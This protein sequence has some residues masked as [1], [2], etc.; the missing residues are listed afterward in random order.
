MSH[1]SQVLESFINNNKGMFLGNSPNIKTQAEVLVAYNK[2]IMQRQGDFKPSL[3]YY[4]NLIKN[5][6]VDLD[7]DN[8]W[9]AYEY[10]LPYMSAPDKNLLL[11]DL[12]IANMLFCAQ[13]LY[14]AAHQKTEDRENYQK[15]SS[16]CEVLVNFL[17]TNF[18]NFIEQQK[19]HDLDRL[20]KADLA[21]LKKKLQI[22]YHIALLE[23]AEKAKKCQSL[24]QHLEGKEL[25]QTTQQNQCSDGNPVAYLGIKLAQVLTSTKK[26]RD[27]LN[28]TNDKRLYWVW[29][30]GFV[31]LLLD[32]A[33]VP[34]FF[35][36]DATETA[37]FP[38]PFTGCMSW[39][40][41]F[42][43]LSMNL[44]LFF[45]H[46]LNPSEDEITMPWKERTKLQTRKYAI[47]NDLF[48]GPLNLASI[49]LQQ[50]K[51][52]LGGGFKEVLA[53]DFLTVILLVF[54]LL[55][56]FIEFQEEKESFNNDMKQFFSDIEALNLELKNVGPAESGIYMQRLL[57]LNKAKSQRENEWHYKHQCLFINIM[58]SLGLLL[59]FS[60]V[61]FAGSSLAI[62]LAGT[63]LCFTLTVINNAS[64]N[65]MEIHKTHGSL[66]DIEKQT[67]DIINILKTI[68]LDEQQK[69]YFFMKLKGLTA[70]TDYQKAKIVYQTMHFF[71]SLLLEMFIIP[72]MIFL[73]LGI[74]VYPAIFAVMATTNAL[75]SNI[76][77]IEKL[78]LTPFEQGEYDAFTCDEDWTKKP[79]K[80]SPKFFNEVLLDQVNVIESKP[81][82]PTI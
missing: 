72:S 43:R 62:V 59:A 37:H 42:F 70:D 16:R 63:I 78:P 73:P 44:G 76:F 49:I 67:S 25:Q 77:K 13:D 32:E 5:P 58:Y 60:M 17:N 52:G 26:V 40:L 6:D 27:I 33:L 9:I 75:I 69:K 23:D 41:Y 48:W 74:A 82:Q 10:L 56:A 20:S 2:N 3:S 81:C 4:Q 39:A 1:S 47:L 80:H 34:H 15:Y 12:Q 55:M 46:L 11:W 50:T 66:K 22:A 54:D 53:A 45:K 38:D 35:N 68:A 64:K 31:K 51:L 57:N 71:R 30:G 7:S 8:C 28:A 14:D 65:A 79:S 21:F 61:A 19:F 18:L 36:Y 29:G 24:L